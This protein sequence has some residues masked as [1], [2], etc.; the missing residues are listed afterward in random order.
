MER[1][2]QWAVRCMHEAQMHKHNAFITL[3]YNDANLPEN[4]SL[5]Y[6]DWQLFFKKLRKKISPTRIRFYMGGE[7]APTH[8]RPHYHACIFG[9]DFPDKI[10]WRTTEAKAK[11]YTSE[12]L[13]TTW[14]KGF[15][16]VGDVTFESAAYVA[17][18]IM[19][20]TTGDKNRIREKY[21]TVDVETGEIKKRIP[22]FNKMSLK[23]GIGATWL[24][25]YTPD[26][27]PDGKVVINGREQKTPK[28]Y[29][30]KFAKL[31]PLAWEQLQYER[32]KRTQ[33]EE[34]TPERLKVR[35]TVARARTKSLERK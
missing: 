22:E 14:A 32:E 17:R 3:T 5:H 2:R 29:D 28:Y 1:A 21:E 10:Y 31:N 6:R 24:E 18:Y 15:T 13:E 35:E 26:A 33:P 34:Q 4:A 20:K 25:K 9:Y 23:P 16:T 8:Q 30:K 11:L 12:E 19:D 7:Y 27:Y